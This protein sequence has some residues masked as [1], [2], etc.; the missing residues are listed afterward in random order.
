MSEPIT[1]Q[2]T[3]T[4]SLDRRL[5]RV[6]WPL[7][8]S[9]SLWNVQIAVDRMMLGWYGDHTAGAALAGAILFWVPLALLHAT[10]MYSSTFVAQ[11][12]GAGRS[13]RVGAVVWQGIW[14]ALAGG[15]LLL[16]LIPLLPALIPLAGHPPD[17]QAHEIAYLRWLVL[18]GPPMLLLVAASSF[19]AGRG[20]S[21]VIMQADL[22]GVSVNLVV[23]ST[24]IF[25]FWGLPRMGIEGAGIAMVA[26]NSCAAVFALAMLFRPRYEAEFGLRAGW[27]LDLSL[28]RR[29]LYFG[30]PSGLFV[31]VDVLSWALFIVFIGQMGAN[32]LTVSTIAFTL[33]LFAYL[34]AMGLSQAVGVL[35]GQAQGRGDSD[36]AAAVTWRG[37]G[38]ALLING[39]VATLFLIIPT[40]LAALFHDPASGASWDEVARLVTLLLRFVVVYVLFDTVNL[41]MSHALR[42]AGDTRYVSILA[43]GLAWPVMVLPTLAA[44]HFRLGMFFAWTGASVFIIL[45]ALAFL[46][47]FQGGKW[48]SLRVIEAAPL[49][50][51]PAPAGDATLPVVDGE[52]LARKPDGVV[53][54]S[55]LRGVC[56]A[57]DRGE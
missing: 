57:P 39:A 4:G 1:L 34:P 43:L 26:G 41:V 20:E 2:G 10:V 32:E 33:N 51:C 14:V 22:I 9:T 45:L 25:G 5:W 50:D 3:P 29:M 37:L 12:Q 49:I 7:I 17:I 54:S 28:L 44:V 30:L 23:G 42:A 40:Y 55:Q 48:R 52:W 15:L 36:E 18:S 46:W 27:R 19:F 8:I 6:A 11:Y 47:R 24:L 13:R 21:V 56:E 38:Y 16:L 31:M 53:S 35:V